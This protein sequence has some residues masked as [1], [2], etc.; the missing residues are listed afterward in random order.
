MKYSEV[1]EYINNDISEGRA[2]IRDPNLENKKFKKIAKGKHVF[3]GPIN[4]ENG[5]LHK[6]IV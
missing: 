4:T 5:L 6:I 3:E 2:I 1:I